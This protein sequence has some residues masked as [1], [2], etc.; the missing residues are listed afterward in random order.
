MQETLQAVRVL[1]LAG[2]SDEALGKAIR[3]YVCNA[4]LTAEQQRPSGAMSP[5][6]DPAP[7]AHVTHAPERPLAASSVVGRPAPEKEE[8]VP[9]KVQLSNGTPT[10][11][12]V[13]RVLLERVARLKGSEAEARKVA[14]ELV[15]STP[16]GEKRS[17]W[18]VAELTK[19]VGAESGLSTA[20]GAPPLS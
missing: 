7:T 16:P 18:V 3:E 14:R 19:L 20:P 5:A 8:L 2:I 13:P 17:G 9:I 10:N 6:L 15:K 1:A 4:G 12:V 11:I